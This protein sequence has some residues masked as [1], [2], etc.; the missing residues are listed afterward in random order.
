VD[1]FLA[2]PPMPGLGVWRSALRRLSQRVTTHSTL[3]YLA[4]STS[5]DLRR[6]TL[7]ALTL[8]VT[9]CFTYPHQFLTHPTSTHL[10]HLRNVPPAE[11]PLRG[12]DPLRVV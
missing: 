10:M 2:F 7:L 3:T 8:T 6:S 1:P 9:T 4:R 11:R 12:S 5:L